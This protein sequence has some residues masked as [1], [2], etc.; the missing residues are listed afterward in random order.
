MQV[1][2]ACGQALTQT[3]ERMFVSPHRKLGI[4]GIGISPEPKRAIRR[5]SEQLFSRQVEDF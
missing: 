2:A 3:V 4:L 5:L 1:I